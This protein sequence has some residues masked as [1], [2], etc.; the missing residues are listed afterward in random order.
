MTATIAILWWVFL[1]MA[2][3][4]TVVDV[5]FLVKVVSLARQIHVLAGATVP[6]AVGIVRNTT[7]GDALARTVELVITLV[8]QTAAVDPLTARVV[9]RLTQRGS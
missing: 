4:I 8:K 9:Q 3:L 5:Y 6:A 7:A 2:L 1:V